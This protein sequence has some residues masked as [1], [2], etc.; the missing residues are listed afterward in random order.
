MARALLC[1]PVVPLTPFTF[2]I[3]PIQR[4]HLAAR[5]YTFMALVISKL[6]SGRFSLASGV[7]AP[8]AIVVVDVVAIA[9]N[10]AGLKIR[11]SLLCFVTR[12]NACI[13]TLYSITF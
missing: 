11:A 8:L 10:G 1:P 6:Q 2:T 9:T 4:R 12:V 7:R 3:Q 5:L 13:N